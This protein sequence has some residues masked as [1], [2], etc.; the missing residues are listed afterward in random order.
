MD[1]GEL[2]HIKKM[3]ENSI[4]GKSITT[5]PSVTMPA[6]LTIMTGLYQDSYQVPLIHWYDRVNKKIKNYSNN[7]QAFEI[8]KDIGE[9]KTIFEMI[10]GYSCNVFESIH[11]GATYN[12]PGKL[13]AIIKYVYYRYLTNLNKSNEIVNKRILKVFK[14]PNKY[15]PQ[16]SQE[17]PKLTVGW[18][19]APDILLHMF[20]ANSEAYL[21]G[22]KS[23][24]KAIGDLI[25]GLKE[26][27]ILDETII[28]ITSDHGNYTANELYNPQPHL[29]NKNLYPL[30]PKKQKGDY[31]VADG[32]VLGF[33][34]SGDEDNQY[35]TESAL[36]NYNNIDVIKA[37]QKLKGIKWVAYRSD[38]NTPNKGTFQIIRKIND[39]WE[40]SFIHYSNNKT[41]YEIENVDILNYY[42]KNSSP[43]WLDHNKFYSMDEWLKNTHDLDFPMFPDQLFR[44]FQNPNCC[45][46]F[47][48]SMAEIVYNS[49]HGVVKK[50]FHIHAHDVAL[51]CSMQVPLMIYNPLFKEKKII[52][53]KT[54][55]IIPTILKILN[56][57]K[58]T[59]L[60]GKNL[61]NQ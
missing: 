3:R 16:K 28:I 24:D 6:H 12:Y 61:L 4:Y 29:S 8:Y 30:Q 46:L 55:D 21:N 10:D 50:N 32:S 39:K 60:C 14:K 34:F 44:N 18:F 54:S 31:D 20:G 13:K 1:N 26:L 27:K 5:F 19:L 52:F 57:K 40:N 35:K 36:R 56:I 43:D 33:Y 37:V 38:N 15:L 47:A 45:D 53:S 2:P 25:N 22:L 17:I 59:Y 11:R 9:V 49:V 42:N 58:P 48:S 51:R 7:L 23:V 41:R